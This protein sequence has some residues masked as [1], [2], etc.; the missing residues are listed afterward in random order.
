MQR[1]KIIRPGKMLPAM[2]VALLLTVCTWQEIDAVKMGPGHLVVRIVTP[3]HERASSSLSPYGPGMERELLDA[4]LAQSDRQAAFREVSDPAEAL[5][6]LESGEADIMAGFALEPERSFWTP[7]QVGPAYG[8]IRP[9]VVTRHGDSEDPDGQ[10]PAASAACADPEL[11]PLVES[12]DPELAGLGPMDSCETSFL[13]VVLGG[14]DQ[15]SL[16]MAV[17]DRDRFRLWQPFYGDLQLEEQGREEL[18]LRWIWRTDRPGLSEQVEDFWQRPE[19]Q[20]L[21][22]NL[23]ERYFGFLPNQADHAELEHISLTMRTQVDQYQQAIKSAA[24]TND[25]DPLFLAAV[26]YQE[27]RFNADARSQTG[28][29]GLM[30]LT[31]ATAQMLGV[32]DRTDPEQSIRGGSAYLRMLWEDLDGL[33]LDPWDRWCFT[34]A[35]YNQGPGN[36]NRA[37]RMASSN[38][39]GTLC[40]NDLRKAYLRLTSADGCRGRE[41]VRFVD[42]V[43]YFYYILHGF[44]ALA[45]PEA[46]HLAPLLGGA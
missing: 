26:I 31:E 34:L 11:E 1:T 14:L 10:S 12:R 42:S 38:T 20:E 45:R 23:E 18:S 40:W 21:A 44:V 2:A 46:Q 30:Q 15:R 17:V 35:A 25:I 19:T 39:Q 36:L 32:T 22:A 3:G 29:R 7:I 33:G 37:M 8:T 6:A 9:A 4:F 16:S 13:P 41:A 27:S 28:V 24:A 5:A 43:R